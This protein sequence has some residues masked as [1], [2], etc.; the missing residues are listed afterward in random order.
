MEGDKGME[1]LSS[2]KRHHQKKTKGQQRGR[3][4]RGFRIPGSSE[5]Q[6][7]PYLPI[8]PCS[9]SHLLI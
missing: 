9:G 3:A 4:V 6:T 2:R 5:V 1:D 7:G 8:G